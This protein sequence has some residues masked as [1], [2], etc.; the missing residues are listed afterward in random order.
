MRLTKIPIACTLTSTD[1]N[2]RIAEWRGFLRDCVTTA[3]RAEHELQLI[4][5]P[6]DATLLRAV[7]LAAR[8]RA[9]CGFFSFSIEI[10][11]D[12]RTLVIGVPAEATE[13]LDDMSGL[14]PAERL[15]H[16]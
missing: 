8:E 2:D 10:E 6:G 16:T 15:P 3:T 13:V 1:A 12:S 9:C 5:E 7:D 14:I 11:A 4:L